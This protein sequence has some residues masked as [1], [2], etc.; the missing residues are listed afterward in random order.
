MDAQTSILVPRYNPLAPKV[1]EDPYPEYARLR[2][3]GPLC[4]GGPGQ[5][6][7]TRYDDVARLLAD[8]SLSSEYPPI[9]R[10]FS[11]GSGSTNS[12]YERILLYRDQPAH[13]RLRALLRQTLT[14]SLLDSLNAQLPSVVDELLQP[15][16]DHRSFDVVS[17]FAIPLSLHV[18]C[19]LIG[20]PHSE[21]QEVRIRSLDLAKAFGTR[22]SDSDRNAADS[23]VDWLRDYAGGLLEKRNRQPQPDLLSQIARAEVGSELSR[24]DIVDNVAFL[25]FAGFET[26]GNLVANGIR[27]LLGDPGEFTRLRKRPDLLPSAADELLRYDPPIQG[28][29]RAVRQPLAIGGRIIKPGRVLVLLLGSANRDET[30][31]ADPDR[32]DIARNPNPHLSFGGGIH[33]CLG[34][35]LARIELIAALSRLLLRTSSIALDG[36]TVRRLDTRFRCYASIPVA[37]RRA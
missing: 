20:F 19:E 32:I 11:F 12:F 24:E 15:A 14:P 10:T 30:R 28:V 16:L 25:L 1:V 34:A 18:I 7:V 4:R 22:I 33:H 36:P 23:A 5:W 21:A 29:A 13:G 17:D 27:A 9:Y 35:S 3:A 31:F 26:T 6:A 8:R 2:K 37:V